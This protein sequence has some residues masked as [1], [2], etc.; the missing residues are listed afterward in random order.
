MAGAISDPRDPRFDPCNVDAYALASQGR[1]LE[2]ETALVRFSRLVDGLP[3]QHGTARWSVRGEMGRGTGRTGVISGQPLL[4]LHVQAELTLQCQ[5]CGEP[6]TFA[7]DAANVLQL[8]ESEDDLED[9]DFGSL[10]ALQ[11]GDDPDPEEAGDSAVG[12]PEKV[13]GSRH[14]DLLAQVEDELILNVPYVPRHEV[15]PGAQAS[16]GGDPEP[17]ERRPSPFAVLEQLKRKT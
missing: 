16:A 8:V 9:P 13:V 17:A 6:F 2:G 14:F 15:C 5:R 11:E 1:A 3:Q 10:G 12:Y 4:R 7:V